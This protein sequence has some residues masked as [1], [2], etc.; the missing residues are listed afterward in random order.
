M[1]AWGITHTH[2][3]SPRTFSAAVLAVA[4]STSSVPCQ[5][6]ICT[7]IQYIFTHYIYNHNSHRHTY[8]YI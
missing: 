5:N 2:N 8:M 4:S 7:H 6:W 1:E 3:F